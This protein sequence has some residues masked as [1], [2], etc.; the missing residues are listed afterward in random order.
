MHKQLAHYEHAHEQATDSNSEL[1]RAV[2]EHSPNLKL[3][4][5]PL[6]DLK[7]HLSTAKVDEGM[8]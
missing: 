1:Q 7:Q 5:M 4:T 6:N 2:A 3:L 8:L